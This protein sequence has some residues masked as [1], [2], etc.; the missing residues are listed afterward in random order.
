MRREEQPLGVGGGRASDVLNGVGVCAVGGAVATAAGMGVGFVS[1]A[2]SVF[3]GL[4]SWEGD[5]VSGE[6]E[7]EEDDLVFSSGGVSAGV[8]AQHVLTLRLMKSLHAQ[9]PLL[10]V[11]EPIQV[12]LVGFWSKI[13]WCRA[14]SKSASLL[15][16]SGK[17]RCSADVDEVCSRAAGG[18]C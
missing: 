17:S 1:S 13:W 3:L 9:V 15:P 10:L 2:A 8:Y 14:S 11:R 6:S 4:D 16:I 12:Q 7:D 5:V 18:C